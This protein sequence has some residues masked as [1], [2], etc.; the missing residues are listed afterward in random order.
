MTP[1]EFSERLSPK[2]HVK[3]IYKW[4]SEGRVSANRIG[5]HLID[6]PESEMAKLSSKYVPPAAKPGPTIEDRLK[7]VGELLKNGSAQVP[8]KKEP[9]ADPH[10]AKET[11][12]VTATTE[13]EQSVPPAASTE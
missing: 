9:R 2:V 4:L 1:K 11:A 13:E 6:I 10:P 3:T 12:D 8:P 5:P 7:R